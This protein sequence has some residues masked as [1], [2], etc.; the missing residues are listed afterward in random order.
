MKQDPLN[1]QVKRF[2]AGDESLK[3]RI[4]ANLVRL[5]LTREPLQYQV[6]KSQDCSMEH[7]CSRARLLQKAKHKKCW[8]VGSTSSAPVEARL[9]RDP[10]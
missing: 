8:P 10:S 5:Q 6:K 9:D 1:C 7:A 4:H 2:E 3:T